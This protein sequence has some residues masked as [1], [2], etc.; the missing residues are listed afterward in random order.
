MKSFFLIALFGIGTIFNLSGQGVAVNT[1]GAAAD[2]S[3]IL[4]VVSTTK[5]FLPPRMTALQRDAISSPVAGLTIYCTTENCVNFYNGLF[6]KS[7]CDEINYRTCNNTYGYNTVKAAGYTWLDRNLGAQRVATAYS[8]YRAYGHLYQWGRGSDGHQC[9]DWSSATV[10]WLMNG[11]TSTQST[12]DD[13]GHD[14]FI[15]RASSPFDWRNPSNDNLWQVANGINNPCPGGDR[16]PTSAEFAAFDA[17]ISPDNAIGAFASPLK[18]VTAGQIFM[19]GAEYDAGDIGDYWS[20]TVT[21]SGTGV[22]MYFVPV[23]GAAMINVNS[24]RCSSLSI[25]CIRD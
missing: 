4:D 8:D 23:S 16:I 18:L 22:N 25:R 15:T 12:T 7:S 6:W 17:T 20:S 2:N 1:S 21:G 10:G 11:T 5:G 24:A 3:S 19:N 9:I 13:P 14:D